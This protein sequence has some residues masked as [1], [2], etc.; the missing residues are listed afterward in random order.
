MRLQTTIMLFV[1]LGWVVGM[2]T[3]VEWLLEW[4]G[5]L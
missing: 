4:M 3:L 2:A 5:W 1:L